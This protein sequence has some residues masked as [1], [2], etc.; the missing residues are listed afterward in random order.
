MYFANKLRAGVSLQLFRTTGEK[1]QQQ[2]AVQLLTSCIGNWK[3]IAQITSGHYKEVPYVDNH[4]SGG[5]AYKDALTF[6]WAK[7]LPQV[8]RDVL[9]ATNSKKITSNSF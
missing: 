9:M 4:A 8:E 7:Y 1:L 5:V 3:K 6:S 2:R